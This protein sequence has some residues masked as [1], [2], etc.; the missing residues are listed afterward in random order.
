M[1]KRMFVCF[2]IMC[3][4]LFSIP[5]VVFGSLVDD[6]FSK[7]YDLFKR[8]D[9]QELLPATLAVFKKD[10]NQKELDPVLL[11]FILKGP[12][13]L[14]GVDEEFNEKFISLLSY[15]TGLRALFRDEQFYNVLTDPKEIDKLIE[16]IEAIQVPT[17]LG[18]VSGNGQS[19]NPGTALAALVVVVKDQKEREIE[20]VS[21]TFSITSGGG[22]LSGLTSSTNSRGRAATI[23]TLGAEPGTTLVKASV[24]GISETVTFI[25]ITIPITSPPATDT[26]KPPESELFVNI[27]PSEIVSPAADKNIVLNIRIKGGESITGYKIIV[28]YDPS[29]IRYVN[30]DRKFN[31]DYLPIAYQLV[32]KVEGED[33]LAKSATVTLV[34][35]SPLVE[36]SGDGILARLVFTVA[37]K[38]ESTV[39]LAKVELSD[40]NGNLLSPAL[41]NAHIKVYTADVD[42]DGD[43]DDEDLNKVAENFGT[44]VSANTVNPYDV[45]N[46]KKVD[47]LDLVLVSQLF[48]SAAINASCPKDVP[49]DL[50]NDGEVNI[51]DLVLV[52]GAFGAT[53]DAAPSMLASAQGHISAAEVRTWIAQ[54]KVLDSDIP[55]TTKVDPAYQRG[56]AVLE[57]LLATLTHIEA[58]PQKTALLLNYPNPFNPETWIPYQLAEATDVTVTIHAMNGTLIRTLALGHQ[59][60]GVYRN[61][62]RAAYWDGKNEFG[63][64]VASGLYFYTL[65]AGNFRATG[66]ML[67]RK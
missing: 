29:A 10:S 1:K 20:G 11:E 64:R 51:L 23:L 15:D 12:R 19:G 50:N 66:K 31:C 36:N 57:N 49:E 43:I 65:T 58:A 47:I 63:E 3:F 35:V 18:I 32:E 38:K 8:P 25:A 42:G 59:A 61:K 45:N 17:T 2:F 22:Q 62:S 40:S 54:A 26:P 52:A 7:Y 41:K 56:V 16:K 37:E 5:K 4:L 53:E 24:K 46:D 44:S 34:A 33:P 28:Q 48:S 6:V 60:A 27:T 21:V 9:I 13:F 67:I 14:L 39:T 55:E 30:K